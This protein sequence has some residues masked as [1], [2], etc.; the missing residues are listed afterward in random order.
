MSRLQ[1][2]DLCSQNMVS[3]L[4]FLVFLASP[5]TLTR[6]R[7]TRSSVSFGPSFVFIPGCRHRL[8]SLTRT[9]LAHGLIQGG[10]VGPVLGGLAES[11]A[12]NYPD[13]YVGQMELFKTYPYLFPCM[14]ASLVSPSCF[15]D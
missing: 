6:P 14:L 2:L 4:P 13:S 12:K 15:I 11:P 3:D 10:V 7:R 5:T 8:P 1:C 9:S